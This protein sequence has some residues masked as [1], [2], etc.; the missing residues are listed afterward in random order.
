MNEL[1]KRWGAAIALT[2]M[3]TGQIGV[4][5]SYAAQ[6]D[7][8]DLQ[9]KKEKDFDTESP[10]KHVIVLIGENRTFDN[11]Y[12]TYVPKPGQSVANLLSKGIVNGDGSPGPNKDAAKQFHIGNIN[13]LSYFISTNTL[14]NPQKM[15]YAPFLPTPEAGGAPPRQETLAQFQKDPAPSAIPF[16]PNTFSLN[17]LGKFTQGIK[18]KDLDLLTT[19]ATGLSNCTIDPTE[20]PSACP[21]PDMRVDNFDHLPNTVFQITGPKLPYDSHTG[22]MVHRFFHMWQQSD[23]DRAFSSADNPAGCLNDLY[24]FVGIARGDDSGSNAMGFYNIQKGDAPVFKE[25]ADEYTMSD[26]FHQSVMGGTAANHVALGTGDAIFWMTFGGMTQPPASQVADPTPTSAT[27][28]KYKKDKAWTDCGD[29]TQPGVQPILDYLGKL[30]YKPA[31]NCQNVFY[32]VNNLSPGFEPNGMIDSASVTAGAKVPPSALRTIGDELNDSNIS[33]AYYSG[34]YNAAVRVADGSTDP[35]DLAIAPNYCDICNF[36][37]YATSIMGSSTQRAMHIKDA[38]DFFADLAAG[39]LPAVSFVKPDSFVDGH[40]ASSKLGLFEAMLENIVDQMGNQKDTALFV[41]F[42]EGGGYWDSGYYQPLDFF[43]DGPRIP[44]LVVSNYA[45]HGQV[46]HTY[47]DH[48]SILKFIE[49]NWGLSPLTGRSRDNLPNPVTASGN[50][51][52]PV[53]SPAIGD[54]MDMFDFHSG[55]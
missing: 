49:R 3:L 11:V 33:W 53:N 7:K 48:V 16:D 10:I 26:N 37:S 54:L 44:F 24:P 14:T 5:L 40:P 55:H 13:P 32:M 18:H 38:T 31:P 8:E 51:Y 28:D 4:P 25:L 22:D 43:G 42:D 30:P 29:P 21:E 9:F 6:D 45:K 23:C 52:V 41:A 2:A 46:V 36:E 20:P 1:R 47:Y 17:L 15:A 19:G 39:T 12:G 34:G 27:S 50:P 35:T